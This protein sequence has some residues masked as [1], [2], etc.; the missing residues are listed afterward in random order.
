MSSDGKKKN[1]ELV[2]ETRVIELALALLTLLQFR[3]GND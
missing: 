1:L 3:P 2:V